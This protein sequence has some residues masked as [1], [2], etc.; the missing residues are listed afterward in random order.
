M[1]EQW[2]GRR[3]WPRVRHWGRAG[4]SGSAGLVPPKKNGG[5]QAKGRCRSA[6]RARDR[7]HGRRTC[8]LGHPRARGAGA[9]RSGARA[10]A[11][12]APA[13]GRRWGWGRPDQRGR[14]RRPAPPPLA[15][16][17][18]DVRPRHPRRMWRPGRPPRRAGGAVRGPLWP[19]VAAVGAPRPSIS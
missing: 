19:V 5:A 4:A 1:R 13:A 10:A 17:V 11:A 3:G 6:R 2:R 18:S 15:M 7:A 16:E 12:A 8:R 14:Q 9:S